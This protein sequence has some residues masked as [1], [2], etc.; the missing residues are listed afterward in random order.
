MDASTVLPLPFIHA[1]INLHECHLVNFF[2]LSSFYQLGLHNKIGVALAKL[3][4]DIYQIKLIETRNLPLFSYAYQKYVFV[5][6]LIGYVCPP[7]CVHY[8]A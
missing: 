6:F 3:Q 1:L 2:M 5:D 7:N 8:R 4:Q